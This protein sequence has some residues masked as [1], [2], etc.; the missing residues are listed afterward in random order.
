MSH[1]ERYSCTK[2]KKH[3]LCSCEAAI[4]FAALQLQSCLCRVYEKK[5]VKYICTAELTDSVLI[6]LNCGT[7]T[8][9]SLK[10]SCNNLSAILDIDCNLWET[11]ML[12]RPLQQ[13]L[14]RGKGGASEA[15]ETH[16]EAFFAPFS[17][18]K[19]PPGPFFLPHVSFVCC[20][21]PSGPPPPPPPLGRVLAYFSPSTPPIEDEQQQG[22]SYVSFVALLLLLPGSSAM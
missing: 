16:R 10:T 15:G 2:R 22:S 17:L 8:T 11:L 7:T 21:A 18:L 20:N 4:A 9:T 1:K 14:P 5:G 12:Q 3:P 13:F 6:Q 19:P